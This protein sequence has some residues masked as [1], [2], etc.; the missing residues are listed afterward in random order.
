MAFEWQVSAGPSGDAAA[1]DIA[2]LGPDV[3]GLAPQIWFQLDCKRTSVKQLFL[4][5]KQELS[6]IRAIAAV[7]YR[8]KWRCSSL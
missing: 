4:A 5:L 6:A 2:P 1:P 8:T 7:F 3:A